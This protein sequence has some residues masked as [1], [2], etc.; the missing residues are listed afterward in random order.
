MKRVA[1][2]YSPRELKMAVEVLQHNGYHCFS[3]AD[4]K[5]IISA[6]YNLGFRIVYTGEKS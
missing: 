3:E 5:G 1:K 2:T 4:A 6:L